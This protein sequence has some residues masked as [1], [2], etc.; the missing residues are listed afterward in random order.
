MFNECFLPKFLECV[1]VKQLWKSI[2]TWCIENMD[3]R[4]E[5]GVFFSATR[6]VEIAWNLN[7]QPGK[8]FVDRRQMLTLCGLRQREYDA[9]VFSWRKWVRG[10]ERHKLI[11]TKTL[12][13]TRG[14]CCLDDDRED[15]YLRSN[16]SRR[17][18]SHYW[19]Q[20]ILWG[21]SLLSA[22]LYQ[23]LNKQVPVPVVQVPVQVP[24][25]GMTVRYD[26]IRWWG[27]SVH[28]KLTE[29]CQFN[30]VHGAK[31]IKIRN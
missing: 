2:N 24:V 13:S 14:S 18:I 29:N 22:V 28:L 5:Y 11:S 9:D 26:A 15:K 4:Q 16:C 12:L 8:E 17:L 6:C 30:L 7:C 27:F 3:K 19:T 21:C 25:L 31:Q 1:F 23:V 20:F 10:S